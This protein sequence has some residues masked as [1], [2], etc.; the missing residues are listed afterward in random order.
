VKCNKRLAREG[1]TQTACL[2]CCDDVDG[3]IS[4]QKP[5]AQAHFKEQ[6]LAGTTL[7]Q[8]EANAKRKLQLCAPSK[9]K[10]FFREPGF[11]YQGDTVVIWDV[12]AYAQNP[13]WKEDAIRK[14]LRRQKATNNNT[15]WEILPP[16]RNSRKR[17]HQ[18][19]EQWYQT[20]LTAD[21]LDSS[22]V[23]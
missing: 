12:R 4:H 7:V 2:H 20:S 1:C 11:K 3:C 10:F 9:G 15:D 23:N 5:R 16:L 6:I 22:R 19:V 8:Q 13:R 18:L 14:A 21:K 17:F